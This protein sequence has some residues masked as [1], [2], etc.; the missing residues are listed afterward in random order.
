MADNPLPSSPIDPLPASAEPVRPQPPPP[1]VAA[2]SGLLDQVKASA[3]HLGLLAG[4]WA[5]AY[6]V[7]LLL[8]GLGQRD[9]L[10]FATV[11]AIIGS[12]FV[13]SLLPHHDKSAAGAA[14]P[15]HADSPREIVETVVFVVVLVLLLKSFAA[16]AFVIP[17]G[18]MAETLWGYQ[19][20]V[21][22]PQC[23]LAFPVNCSSEVDPPD[24]EGFGRGPRE[25]LRVGGCVCP[26]CR[27]EI[28]LAGPRDDRLPGDAGTIPD[29]GWR[30]GDRVLVAKFVY[31]LLNQSPDRLDVVV[32]KYPGDPRFPLSGPVKR[33]V[34]IN[35]IKRLIG[36]PNETIGVHRGKLWRL[37][38]DKGL[39]YDET[40][41]R[42]QLWQMR[43]THHNDPEAVRRFSA[44]DFEII[45]KKPESLLTM[46]RLVYDNF[47]QARDLKDERYRRWVASPAGGWTSEPLSVFRSDGSS[48][49]P[50]WL[51]YRH[52]LRKNPDQP[53]LI[54][55]FMGYNTGTVRGMPGENWASD[56]MLECQVQ[57][58]KAQGQLLLEL[59]RGPDRF[60]AV[61]DLGKGE[62]RLFRLEGGKP[63]A[64]LKSV[65]GVLA[66]PGTYQVR[67]A[68]V[69]DRLTVWIDERL[70]F[71]DG[72]EYGPVRKLLPTRQNDLERPASIGSQG[73]AV[74][75][76]GLRLYR[77]TYYTTNRTGT[78]SEADAPNFRPDDAETWSALENLPVAT[79]FVQPDHFLCLGDNSP[80]S[81]DG[82]TW[83]LVPQRLLLGRAL[84]V[85]YP[86]SRA[87]RIR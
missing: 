68:N 78:P 75:V 43:H 41:D 21:T 14:Q 72:I 53:Q 71:G 13:R 22:C 39:R 6:V 30:S 16:E 86:F 63:P 23:A 3:L 45:R 18:S 81:S 61:F 37:A 29:P 1:A 73:A 70:V 74:A 79:Y 83:G 31:D 48:A 46:R 40:A 12:F 56:L 64:E 65:P 2:S 5:A 26:N 36:L 76:S 28:T 11:T 15:H 57:V 58:E 32:F 82:R 62:C 27:Q 54:T 34:P 69:D 52:V 77:D 9:A 49:E 4:L 80:E 55:D 10:G 17:T 38:P 42:A 50:A 60:Q 47:H 66:R 20:V 35:Y 7:L 44:G 19:K 67:F 33:H 85:Y 51:R 8:A 87:G 84:L 24:D 59:S 25:P